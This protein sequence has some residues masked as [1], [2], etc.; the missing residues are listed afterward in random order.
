MSGQYR[1]PLLFAVEGQRLAT[2]SMQGLCHFAFYC[3]L[4]WRSRRGETLGTLLRTELA[5][6]QCARRTIVVPA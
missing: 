4:L 5:P 6:R 2:G 3:T 1:V